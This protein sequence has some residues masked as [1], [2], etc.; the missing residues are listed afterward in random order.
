ML[1]LLH[2]KYNFAVIASFICLILAG[3][4]APS[5][6]HTAPAPLQSYKHSIQVVSNDSILENIFIKTIRQNQRIVPIQN[7][8]LAA[9]SLFIDVQTQKTT[10]MPRLIGAL[11]KLKQPH[12]YNIHYTL[13]SFEGKILTQN[14]L[15]FTS[16][17]E[18]IIS[19]S[20]NRTSEISDI[21]ATKA[22]LKIIPEIERFIAVTPWRTKVISV[23]NINH[24]SIN[25]GQNVGLTIGDILVT[26]TLPKA[27]LEIALFEGSRATLRLL[28]GSLPQVGRSLIPQNR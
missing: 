15:Q 4:G 23:I 21:L 25:A 24:V 19:A 7:E 2:S 26:E 17:P 9:F 14:T 6:L 18:D 10:F 5:Q 20:I 8:G 3:C 27:T 11:K 28:D 1:N 22:A 12:T 13:T 16:K